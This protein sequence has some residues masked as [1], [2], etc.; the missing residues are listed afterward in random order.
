[1][2]LN[3]VRAHEISLIGTARLPN[4]VDHSV[5][6]LDSSTGGE[7]I[8]KMA[9]G[10]GACPIGDR[11]AAG[12]SASGRLERQC[13]LPVMRFECIHRWEMCAPSAQISLKTR[14]DIVR[15]YSSQLI[16]DSFRFVVFADLQVGVLQEIHGV[17]LMFRSD[18]H[19][20]GL[21]RRS[22]GG[23]VRLNVLLPEAEA[24]KNVRG[25][26]QGMR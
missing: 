17:N 26:V 10:D 12:F 23:E 25:H 14:I 6:L 9:R 24:S 13:F 20:G 11:L 8:V 22:D 7:Y 1:M 2:S 4:R 3:A 16:D 15:V 5:V 21:A 19:S 18:V